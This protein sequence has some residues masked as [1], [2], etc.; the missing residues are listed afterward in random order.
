MKKIEI[1]LDETVYEWLNHIS[2]ITGASV[3]QLVSSSVGNII[4][5]LEA[6]IYNAFLEQEK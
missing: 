6:E 2:S 4:I 1:E 3:E 5:D